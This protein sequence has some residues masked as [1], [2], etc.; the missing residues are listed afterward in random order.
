MC[1]FQS[2]DLPA[3]LRLAGSG[4]ISCWLLPGRDATSVNGLASSPC[5]ALLRV[6]MVRREAAVSFSSLQMTLWSD[7]KSAA[8]QSKAGAARVLLDSGH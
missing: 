4:T 7:C 8:S 6:E 2:T 1:L 5:A 3:R